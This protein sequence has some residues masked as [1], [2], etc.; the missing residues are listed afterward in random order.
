MNGA[1]AA[2]HYDDA[3]TIEEVDARLPE[4]ARDLLRVSALVV[5]V[6]QSGDHGDRAPVQDPEEHL[7]LLQP[8]E[9]GEVPTQRQHVRIPRGV[10]DE[11]P[12]ALLV[13]DADVDVGGGRDPHDRFPPPS[14]GRRHGATVPTLATVSARVPKIQKR[15]PRARVEDVRTTGRFAEGWTSTTP[16]RCRGAPGTTGREGWG[17]RVVGLLPSETR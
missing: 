9:V 8:P 11:R 4:E 16:N 10:L 1:N 14:P 5:V 13:P 6:A 17:E 2:P 7:G 15:R 3:R 12:E